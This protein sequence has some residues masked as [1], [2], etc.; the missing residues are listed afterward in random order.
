VSVG[1]E[2][3]KL[4]A[5]A[6]IYSGNSI[7]ETVKK[8]K[9]TDIETGVEYISTK[10]VG[11]DS[12]INYDNGVKIPKDELSNF[13]TAPKETVFI[14]A[15]GG[16]AG[17]KIAISDRELCFVN[18]LFAIVA[19][20]KALPKYIF[21]S[22]QT[23][24]FINQ[25]KSVMTGI[26]GG[27][28]LNKFKELVIQIPP[29]ESQ[30]EIVNKLD[31]AFVQIEKATV[32]SKANTKN[33]EILFQSYLTEVFEK[34]KESHSEKLLSDICDVRDGTHDSPK[35]IEQGIPFVTQKNIQKNG[36]N[37]D[38]VKFISAEDHIKFHKRS[39]V[40]YGDILI[41]MIGAN[42]G[43]SAIVDEERIFSIKNVCL[44][45]KGDKVNQNYLLYFFKSQQAQNYIKQFSNGGAQE[46]I[47][48]TALR[49]LPVPIASRD[50]Q[51]KVI[52]KLNSMFFLTKSIE[53]SNFEKLNYL[54]KLK[55][56]I[57]KKAFDGTLVKE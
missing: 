27:V 39:N 45:K 52:D 4:S 1:F 53:T 23:N 13:K 43:M 31:E 10:D 3:L 30:T 41:S 36:L 7:N 24:D 32:A 2:T 48:L 19:N 42:R 57:L 47:G 15:E 46:F 18:K 51:D 50:E 56:S 29:L 21:Y 34:I 55:Q 54:G 8:K 37:I 12:V 9:F 49:K 33:A 25:F 44:V 20:D 35:Y 40:T 14:C 17:R 11:F 28:S 22:L 5:V 26:I 6:K 16:S 38:D